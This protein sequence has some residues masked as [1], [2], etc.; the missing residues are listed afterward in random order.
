M[1]HYRCFTTWIINAQAERVAET[2][3]WYPSKVNMPTASSSEAAC[4]VA[5]DALWHPMTASALSPLADSEHAA[6]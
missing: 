3:V 1:G 5:R 6:L 4:V 2:V